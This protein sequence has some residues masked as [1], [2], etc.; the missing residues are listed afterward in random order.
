MLSLEFV[1]TNRFFQL[2]FGIA[3]VAAAKARMFV[4]KPDGSIS[5]TLTFIPITAFLL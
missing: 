2:H 3:E 4:N 5:Q 1:F